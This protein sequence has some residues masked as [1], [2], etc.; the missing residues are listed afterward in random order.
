[1][2][3][4]Q[5]ILSHGLLIALIAAALLL[6]TNRTELFSSKS[7][8]SKVAPVVAVTTAM[9]AANEAE[10]AVEQVIPEPELV[11]EQAAESSQS[12]EPATLPYAESERE[13]EVP[14]E[15]EPSPAVVSIDVATHVPDDKSL[16]QQLDEAREL[17]WQHDVHA[18]EAVYQ[19]LGRDYPKNSDVWGEIGNFYF[20]IRQ[21]HPASRAYY[22]TVSLLID[23]GDTQ[24]ARQL[25][26][27]LYQL[28]ADRGRELDVRL[29][30]S[31]N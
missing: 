2:R 15:P 31:S 20:S 1:M 13:A 21:S 4:L 12:D 23:A 18:A 25:L 3:V 19:S 29:Q 17:Y 24:K 28:D 14:V 27:V 16:Q 7:G 10:E 30:Q 8:G 6:Y 11:P 9:A 26:G 22:R 5:K